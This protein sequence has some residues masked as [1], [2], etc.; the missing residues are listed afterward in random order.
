MVYEKLWN[1]PADKMRSLRHA[2]METGVA[3]W[4]LHD[5][6][7]ADVP[8]KHSFELNNKNPIAHRLRRI[9]PKHNEI[10]R[11][12]LLKMLDAGIMTPYVS[13]WSFPVVIGS[14]NDGTPRFVWTTDL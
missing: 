3:A 12:E 9:P 8:V 2:V 11:T 10:V 7:Q 1:L 5:M 13:G 14:K 6:G 4:S